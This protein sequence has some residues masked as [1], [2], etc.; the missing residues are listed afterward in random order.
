[1]AHIL[2]MGGLNADEVLPIDAPPYPGAHLRA[3]PGR[4]RPGGGGANGALALRLAGHQVTL[5]A[6]VGD[7]ADGH[8]LTEQ[9]AAL[10]LETSGLQVLPK[11]TTNRP[12]ILLD[13]NGERM[14][15][16]RRTIPHEAV[17][18][19]PL[20]HPADALLVKTFNPAF[21]PFM[22]ARASAGTLVVA[23]APPG[24]IDAWPATVWVTSDS[25]Q[26]AAERS[27]PWGWAQSRGGPTLTWL[28][29]T[30]GAAGAEAMSADGARI[31][32]P[33]APISRTVDTTG[34]GDVFAAGL[35]HALVDSAPMDAALAEATRWAARAVQTDGSL[36]PLDLLDPE[37][38][39]A[40]KQERDATGNTPRR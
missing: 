34:A 13:P 25:E 36:P 18:V 4:I 7:D 16:A 6:A 21:A 29:I 17:P 2:V 40:P 32:V 35:T 14:L 30:R 26:T 22:G 33:A 19:P 3:E 12:L 27:D 39:Q 31:A 1:M 15:I 11:A 8:W 9:C 5:W 10:D 24:H 38:A 37:H 23:H 20:N 28:V